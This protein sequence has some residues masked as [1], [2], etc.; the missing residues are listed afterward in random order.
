[1]KLAVKN[2]RN[3]LRFDNSDDGLVV[4]FGATLSQ[5]NTIWLVA[6]KGNANGYYYDGIDGGA[7]RHVLY[8]AE[9]AMFAGS[10]ILAVGVT[11]AN[12]NLYTAAYNTASSVLRANGAQVVAGNAGANSLAAM[13]IGARFSLGLTLDGD[14][15]ELIVAAGLASAATISAVET[16]LNAK[17]GVF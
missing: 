7:T 6:K 2:G 12:W 15:A 16:Y 8:S 17:W 3:V 14:F 4:T 13:T 5:P 10:A 9:P 11:A 1:V